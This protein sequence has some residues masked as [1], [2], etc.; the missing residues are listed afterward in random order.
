MPSLAEM[1]PSSASSET[2]WKSARG[3]YGARS[4]ATS[5]SDSSISGKPTAS[6]RWDGL[7]ALTSG[8]TTTGLCHNPRQRD[9]QRP[10]G[11]PAVRLAVGHAANGDG[12]EVEA[13]VAEFDVAHDAL[14]ML[15]LV[16]FSEGV[17][18]SPLAHVLPAPAPAG[19]G[20]GGREQLMPARCRTVRCCSSRT[21]PRRARTSGLEGG[22]H[23]QRAC[24]RAGMERSHS[25]RCARIGRSGADGT[26]TP[27]SP[28]TRRNRYRSAVSLGRADCR[29]AC[30]YLSFTGFCS[31]RGAT[32][33]RLGAGSVRHGKPCDLETFYDEPVG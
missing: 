13:G 1:P 7:L 19:R 11:V 6:S 3:G 27:R 30:A 31:S 22:R 15:G 10:G 9:L 20:D 23:S 33:L 4:A 5:S 28:N 2:P 18:A 25:S 8:A 26:T 14:L 17:S 32:A 21:N 12:R 16:V 29:R 24:W